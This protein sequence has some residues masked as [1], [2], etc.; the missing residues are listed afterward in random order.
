MKWFWI[1]TTLGVAGFWGGFVATMVADSPRWLALV[2]PASIAAFAGGIG[3]AMM[4]CSRDLRHVRALRGRACPMC[5]YDLTTLPDRGRCPECGAACSSMED[6]AG[7]WHDVEHSAD[8][9]R[10]Y[11]IEEG[12]SNS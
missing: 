2:G 12:A 5:L 11:K 8:A 9:K 1:G 4:R 10:A 7:R 6:V 3:T